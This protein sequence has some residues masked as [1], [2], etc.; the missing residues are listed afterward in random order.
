MQINAPKLTKGQVEQGVTKALSHHM[1]VP[2]SA[3]SATATSSRRLNSLQAERRLAG[4]WSVAF[5]VHVPKT[6]LAA[7]TT[8]VNQIK[9]DTTVLDKI[10]KENLIELGVSET[11]ATVSVTSFSD[12]IQM[13]GATTTDNTETNSVFP[14]KVRMLWLFVLACFVACS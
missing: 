2:E 6:Q 13:P 4:A 12:T 11:D 5:T 8:K 3:V 9:A 14:Q 1:A 7:A 10:L